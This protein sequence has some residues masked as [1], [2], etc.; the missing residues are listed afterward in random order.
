VECDLAAL[1]ERVCAWRVNREISAVCT[2]HEY[3]VHLVEVEA[4]GRRLGGLIRIY[5]KYQHMS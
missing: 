2:A 3:E 1:C 4:Y 5:W